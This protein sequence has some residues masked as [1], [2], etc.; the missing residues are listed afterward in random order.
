MEEQ[1][2]RV[3]VVVGK[4]AEAVDVGGAEGGRLA[5]DGGAGVGPQGR[6]TME[7]RPCRHLHGVADLEAD[8]EVAGEQ[9]EAEG[10]AVVGVEAPADEVV[11]VH[12]VQELLDGLLDPPAAAIRGG[13]AAQ[14]PGAEAGE[15]WG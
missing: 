4:E 1:G 9:A 15:V 6:P 7:P 3:A 11:E 2:V 13:E 5:D 14:P 10:D 12:A 8:G